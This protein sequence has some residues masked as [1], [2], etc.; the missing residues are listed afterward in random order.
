VFNC[1][2]VKEFSKG[3]P[4]FDSKALAAGF[5]ERRINHRGEPLHVRHPQ[6]SAFRLPFNFQISEMTLVI[7]P[8]VIS[9]KPLPQKGSIML[10]ATNAFELLYGDQLLRGAKIIVLAILS[11]V[12]MNTEALRGA[13]FPIV[14]PIIGA[15]PE[16]I[17]QALVRVRLPDEAIED[18]FAN[19]SD[20]HLTFAA[21]QT[22]TG[23]CYIDGR[24]NGVLRLQ[25]RIQDDQLLVHFFSGGI[26]LR[27]PPLH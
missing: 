19:C 13:R 1:G 10:N 7:A 5:V 22:Q 12:R 11:L 16:D 8:A 23:V 18:R 17:G 9:D 3:R 4:P 26:H 20:E 14:L 27:V 15:N 21:Q 24:M 2:T 25:I 6:V